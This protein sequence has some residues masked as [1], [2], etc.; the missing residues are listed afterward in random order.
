MQAVSSLRLRR[1]TRY[2]PIYPYV[3]ALLCSRAYLYEGALLCGRLYLYLA[4]LR[5]GQLMPNLPMADGERAHWEAVRASA[6]VRCEA[7]GLHD[8]IVG[9]VLA[10]GG[11]RPSAGVQL[12]GGY[13]RVASR[14]CWDPESSTTAQG[15][16]RGM[17]EGHRWSPRLHGGYTQAVH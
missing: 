5:R 8:L 14:M 6:S 3:P 9:R 15:S 10:D 12:H 7:A 2:L 4:A 13:T 11:G 1:Y 17:I 16:Q